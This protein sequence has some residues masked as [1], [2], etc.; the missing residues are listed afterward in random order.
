MA[1]DREER[2]TLAQLLQSK[3]KSQNQRLVAFYALIQERDCSRI[4]GEGAFQG[5]R[6][7]SQGEDHHEQWWG[8]QD[9]GRQPQHSPLSSP[10]LAS[11]GRSTQREPTWTQGNPRSKY[12]SCHVQ[13]NIGHTVKR[14]LLSDVQTSMSWHILLGWYPDTP[15][16]AIRRQHSFCFQHWLVHSRSLII[17]L[18]PKKL[19]S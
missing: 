9:L 11:Q 12:G 17:I 13:A 16:A 19:M 14:I 6:G 7:V 3:T 2:R 18:Q 8:R 15:R 10:Q 1:N 4:G 5:K